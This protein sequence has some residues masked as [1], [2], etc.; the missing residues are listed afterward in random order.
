MEGG[1]AVIYVEAWPQRIGLTYNPS[2][3][4]CR[5]AGYEL[6]ANRP[7]ELIDADADAECRAAEAR[8]SAD[9]LVSALRQQYRQSANAF[10]Q[11]AGIEV[12]DKF[13]DASTVATEIEKANAG[14]DTGKAL[15]LT[16]L[17]LAM[18]NLI[19]ELRRKDGDDAWERI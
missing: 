6:L 14:E 18:Q 10:C 4:Q 16:Q 15:R 3:E 19:T 8:A 1:G 13:G 2:P 9:A 11:L 12:V 17:A 5:E 7:Q